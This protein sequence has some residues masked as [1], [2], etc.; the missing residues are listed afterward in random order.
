MKQAKI[1]LLTALFSGMLVSAH[2][3]LAEDVTGTVRTMKGARIELEM[4]DGS[5]Q[6]IDMTKD[7]KVFAEGRP[8]PGRRILKNAVVRVSVKNGN[9][10]AIFVKG[11]PK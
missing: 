11:V 4:N 9:A 1:F 10:E 6:R 2:P 5:I 8:A 7:T 3:A